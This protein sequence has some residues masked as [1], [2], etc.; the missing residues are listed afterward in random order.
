[1]NKYVVVR[2]TGCER[3]IW[4]VIVRATGGVVATYATHSAAIDAARR[5]NGK[6]PVRVARQ[7]SSSPAIVVG[8]SIV[9][10]LLGLLGR[11][12]YGL[13]RDT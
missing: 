2:R 3:P 1:M 13:G 8:G 4:Q 11:K 9:V 6:D 5:M 7:G 10:A 12:A